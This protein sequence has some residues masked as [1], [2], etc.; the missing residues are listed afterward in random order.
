M[1]D[2]LARANEALSRKGEALL[3]TWRGGPRAVLLTCEIREKKDKHGDRRAS[4]RLICDF[5]PFCGEKYP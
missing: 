2:C 3:S 1:C 5:C 4:T